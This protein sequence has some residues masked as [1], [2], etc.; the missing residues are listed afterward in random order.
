ML[1]LLLSKQVSPAPD[2]E[3][4]VALNTLRA[5]A[6]GPRWSR[7]TVT[8]STDTT[9]QAPI[10]LAAPVERVQVSYQ[11]TGT[12]AAALE[13][14]GAVYPFTF[15]GNARA[16]VSTSTRTVSDML[17]IP[18]QPAGVTVRIRTFLAA[19]ASAQ[20]GAAGQ[21]GPRQYAAGDLTLT[22][23][24]AVTVNKGIQDSR[25]TPIILKGYTAA[26][27]IS[28]AGIG[29]SIMEGGTDDGYEN[30]YNPSKPGG[31][32]FSRALRE[33][34]VAGSCYGVWADNTPSNPGTDPRFGDDLKHHTHAVCE[35]GTNALYG[36]VVNGGKDWRVLARSNAR[37]WEWL[38]S[39]GVK[40]AQTTLVPK[41]VSTDGFTTVE[42]QS[43]A[44]DGTEAI[45]LSFNAWVRDKCPMSAGEPVAPGTSGALRAGESGHPLVG[46]IDTDAACRA[47]K[48]N[49]DQVW[50]VDP[51]GV[52][53]VVDGTHP[54]AAG[55]ARMAVPVRDWI[56]AQK[57]KITTP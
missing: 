2:P 35:Y 12:L 9:Y 7:S 47:F 36:V 15:G 25:L 11:H 26:D 20:V 21:G 8:P 51:G 4:G 6:Y 50:D 55:H 54:A 30:I 40:C 44:T 46:V 49:G 3:P 10:T 34:G 28:V 14:G 17:T 23:S 31:G 22:G 13:V 39:Q 24:P 56:T 52:R 45:R 57:A 18:R 41:T 27:R 42:G 33:A 1:A 16:S 37:F 5:V 38:A 29:D 19:G 32:F 53:L 43:V 48:A